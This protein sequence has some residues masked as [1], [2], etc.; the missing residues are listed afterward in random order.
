MIER[1]KKYQ[2]EIFIFF[3]CF[4]FIKSDNSD[5]FVI[6][7]ILY[8]SS[9][10]NFDISFYFWR[11]QN[12]TRNKEILFKKIFIGF[13][14]LF[15]PFICFIFVFFYFS[16][17]KKIC[18]IFITLT[19]LNFCCVFI[20]QETVFLYLVLSGVFPLFFFCC[21]L[22]RGYFF[23][24]NIISLNREIFN[25]KLFFFFVLYEEYLIKQIRLQNFQII[26]NLADF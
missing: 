18:F 20:Q 3:F 12:L 1:D 10:S 15:C 19:V 9:T 25:V 5:N 2:N 8:L 24:L 17:K 26:E 13:F 14:V 23:F 11:V 6:H 7:F 21:R 4:C 16:L 22:K